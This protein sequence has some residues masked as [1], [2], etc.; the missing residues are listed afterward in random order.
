MPT[1]EKNIKALRRKVFVDPQV[2]GALARR[3]IGHWC[4]FMLLAILCL[5]T[6]EVF[7]SEPGD[8]MLRP[9]AAVWSNYTF[10][11]LL[12]LSIIPAFTYD[13]VKLSAR[14]AGPIFRFRRYLR[15][16]GDGENPGELRFRNGDF[17]TELASDFNR[18]VARIEHL[19]EEVRLLNEQLEQQ[20]G[21]PTCV[22]ETH[23]QAAEPAAAT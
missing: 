7:V 5:W 9:L 18:V 17:W 12:M 22:T 13:T 21:A 11:W 19:E 20:Q 15:A 6:V 14:F 3:I 4:M 8:G 23:S 16:V 1:D 2:Q 10:F